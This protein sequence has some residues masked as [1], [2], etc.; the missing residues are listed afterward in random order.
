MHRGLEE[1]ASEY[2]GDTILTP[3]D[4]SFWFDSRVS[5]V[6]VL[7]D[8]VPADR[9]VELAGVGETHFVE[10]VGKALVLVELLEA[11]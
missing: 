7:P 6:V 4:P 9:E 8:N 10:C 2:S 5:A 3:L 11:A 1:E